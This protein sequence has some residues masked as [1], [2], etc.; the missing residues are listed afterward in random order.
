QSITHSRN[1]EDIKPEAL[2][3]H[4]EIHLNELKVSSTNKI[5]VTSIFTKEDPR[6]IPG[7]HNLYSVSHTKE[8]CWFEKPHLHPK[9]PNRSG[10]H[11]EKNGNQNF[12]SFSTFSFSHP[13]VFILDSGSTS[14]MVSDRKLFISLDETEGGMIN[15]SCGPNTLSIEGKGSISMLFSNKPV[16]L[17]DVLLVPN[18][19]VNLLSLHRLLLDRCKVK[20]EMNYFLLEPASHNSNLSVAENLHKSLGH[21]S[22]SR[23]RNKLGIPIAPSDTCRSCAVSK[24]TRAS[25]KHCSSD[26]SRPLE[27]LHL[28]LIGPIAPASHKNHK[29]ILT[30]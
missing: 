14:H 30:I 7:K 22:Y 10:S 25:Y 16:I 11:N 4:L 6:C 26:A 2:L 12:S 8:K 23:I 3:D 29:Y 18:I 17:H 1:G 9:F 28:D 20:F 19:S 5:E 24:I 21:V 13:S 27:E 15:T